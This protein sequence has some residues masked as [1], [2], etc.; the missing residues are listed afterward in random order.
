MIER[1]V[2]N[3]LTRVSER[4]YQFPF[5]QV[6]VSKGFR[7]LHLS[8]HGPQEQGKDIIAVD[9]NG[10]PVCFQLKTGDIDLAALYRLRSHPGHACDPMAC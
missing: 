4:Q 7:V 3:W 9:A 8:S 1:V 10:Q 5:C 2:E 6:L